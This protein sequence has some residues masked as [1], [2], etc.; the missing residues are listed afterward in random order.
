M[1]A[2]LTL[3]LLVLHETCGSWPS[4]YSYSRYMSCALI[5]HCKFRGRFQMRI[6]KLGLSRLCELACQTVTDVYYIVYMIWSQYCNTANPLNQSCS[7]DRS[8][9]VQFPRPRAHKRS[10]TGTVHTWWIMWGRQLRRNVSGPERRPRDQVSSTN[11]VILRTD[12]Q[13]ESQLSTSQ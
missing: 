3:P 12:D 1:C 11:G 13:P 2:T 8:R 5:S 10:I 9:S 6:L 7:S 4:R